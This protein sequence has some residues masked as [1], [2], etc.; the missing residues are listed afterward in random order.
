MSNV[1]RLLSLVLALLMLLSLASVLSACGEDPQT[2]S[3]EENPGDTSD[4]PENPDVKLF[5]TEE[6]MKGIDK[7]QK[8][9]LQNC[10]KYVQKGGALYYSTCSLSKRKTIDK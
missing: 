7:A 5:R 9:I 1:K 8:S 6:D 4:T 2:P 10:A 3:D